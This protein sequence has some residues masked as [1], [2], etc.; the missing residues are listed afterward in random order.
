[1]LE[2]LHHVAVAVGHAR[3]VEDVIRTA[4]AEI[5]LGLGMEMA[6]LYLF[7]LSSRQLTVN[8]YEELSP[9]FAATLPDIRPGESP[10]IEEAITH[11]KAA[12]HRVE[13]IMHPAI[14][15]CLTGQGFQSVAI[16]PLL[17]KDKVFGVL[18][19]GRKTSIE[20]SSRELNTLGA[21]GN[22]VGV[23]VEN[24]E[25][26]EELA[27]QRDQLRAL[28]AG[29]LQTKEMEARRIARNLHDIA[30]QLLTA[31][32]LKLEE[33]AEMAPQTAQEHVEEVRCRLE[34]AQEQLRQLSHELRSPVL[35]DLGLEPALNFLAQGFA[36]RTG[37]EITVEGSIG[38]RLAS[39]IETALYRCVQEALTNVVKHARAK[40]VCIGLHHEPRQ[41]RC[42]VRDDGI[43]FDV[44]AMRVPRGEPGIGL[45][46]IRERLAEIRGT[47]G[48]TSTPGQGTQLTFT[49][50]LK[51]DAVPSDQPAT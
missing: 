16:I 48:I 37:L 31:V 26:Y 32:H 21:I 11:K 20:H 30:G 5:R 23:A 50:P 44:R 17:S 25:L 13:L 14:R 35:D 46:S 40:W 8:P 29:T 34:E 19:M 2:I 38:E 41:F 47:L 4:A 22:V 24:A 28:A 49:V 51:D 42:A 10:L 9:L 43:G 3:K 27:D 15:E 7:D 36:A 1:M 33:L 6:G 45:L 39:A 18:V 12:A